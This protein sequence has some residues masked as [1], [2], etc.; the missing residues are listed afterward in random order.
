MEGNNKI[1][2]II[3]LDLYI[4]KYKETISEKE[5][6]TDLWLNI[7]RELLKSKNKLKMS[8]I[9]ELF[10]I[11]YKN[12][13]SYVAYAIIIISFFIFVLFQNYNK[14]NEK[15]IKRTIVI[16]KIDNNQLSVEQKNSKSLLLQ[17]KKSKHKII[18]INNEI[19]KLEKKVNKKLLTKDEYS[20]I[21]YENSINEI[22]NSINE[23]KDIYNK[24][25]NQIVKQTLN[26]IYDKKIRLLIEIL[27]QN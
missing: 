18:N 4:K 21:F 6:P 27:N 10:K 3:D 15:E 23:C 12:K 16:N 2:K 24:E 1:K 25:K 17:G 8:L 19:N 7:K 11:L 20:K 14:N 22:N 9:K 26:N 5:V 13:I